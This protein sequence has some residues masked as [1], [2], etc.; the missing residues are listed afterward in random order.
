TTMPENDP[1]VHKRIGVGSE[2]AIVEELKG[3]VVG[4]KILLESFKRGVLSR[5]ELGTQ[6]FAKVGTLLGYLAKKS[7]VEGSD[8]EKY[9]FAGIAM[10]DALLKGGGIVESKGS[11]VMRNAELGLGALASIA[12]QFLAM[13]ADDATTPARIKT[14]GQKLREK[15]KSPA[16][17]DF[18]DKLRMRSGGRPPLTARPRHRL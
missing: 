8:G 2:E 11:Y 5:N 4:A 12:D 13:Y 6:F 10:L 7:D 15:K 1:A 14:L 18:L 3:E 17:K 16:I 9:F